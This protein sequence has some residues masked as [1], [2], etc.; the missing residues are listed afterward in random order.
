MPAQK[1]VNLLVPASKKG[2]TGLQKEVNRDPCLFL[3][4]FCLHSD[5]LKMCVEKIMR[6]RKSR[7]RNVYIGNYARKAD[8]KI[9]GGEP[10][11]L[12]K[13]NCAN[14][15]TRLGDQRIRNTRNHTCCQ[16]T[17]SRCLFFLDGLEPFE[18]RFP[19]AVYSRP[20]ALLIRAMLLEIASALE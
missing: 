13:E 11:V 19:G 14:P 18:S 6:W 9:K 8:L 1:R 15:T 3:P 16:F 2:A 4:S 12:K 20:S 17:L 10:P 5:H 7:K